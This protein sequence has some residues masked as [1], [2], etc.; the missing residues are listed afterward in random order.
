ML[1]LIYFAAFPLHHFS[2]YIYLTSFKKW[3]FP[4]FISVPRSMWCMKGYFQFTFFFIRSEHSIS[5][6]RYVNRCLETTLT[7][8]P[9]FPVLFSIKKHTHQKD[10]SGI[11]IYFLILTSKLKTK[12]HPLA[13]F[14]S[15][16]C[17]AV[18]AKRLSRSQGYF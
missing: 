10:E 14:A 15:C 12:K 1:Q 6:D 2:T 9:R 18:V 16:V 17:M 11:H 8:S 3:P 5:R 13:L 7:D 4:T